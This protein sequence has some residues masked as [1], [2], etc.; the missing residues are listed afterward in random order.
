MPLCYAKNHAG[1]NSLAC[2]PGDA[3]L[4]TPD[5]G[6]KPVMDIKPG[7][8][9]AVN[10]NSQ[11]APVQYFLHQDPFAKSQYTD[12]RLEDNTVLTLSA[13]HLIY[14]CRQTSCKLKP[15]REIEPIVESVKTNSGKLLSIIGIRHYISSKGIYAPVT[16]SPTGTLIVNGVVI[17]EFSRIPP[18]SSGLDGLTHSVALWVTRNLPS[19]DKIGMV[20][21]VLTGLHTK[22]NNILSKII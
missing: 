9:V 7:D 4:L 20:P 12:I 22:I 2:L 1:S 8:L 5:K 10:E 15:I 14:A 17:S 16:N 11:F 3:L 21:Y 19:L 13:D 18:L 6:Y